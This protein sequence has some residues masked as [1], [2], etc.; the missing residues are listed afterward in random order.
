MTMSYTFQSSA[1][2]FQGVIHRNWLAAFLQNRRLHSLHLAAPF[3]MRKGCIQSPDFLYLDNAVA[4]VRSSNVLNSCWK[5]VFC[6]GVA[7]VQF[8][9]STAARNLLKVKIRQNFFFGQFENFLLVTRLN[10]FVRFHDGNHIFRCFLH[11]LIR[12]HTRAYRTLLAAITSL[13][14]CYPVFYAHSIILFI[15]INRHFRCSSRF[16]NIIQRTLHPTHQTQIWLMQSLQLALQA[17]KLCCIR[18]D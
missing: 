14:R 7:L 2:F 13:Q 11:Q 15:L 18:T 17:P 12:A 8:L 9:P 5:A 4:Y 10:I 1:F 16:T 6:S 3:S